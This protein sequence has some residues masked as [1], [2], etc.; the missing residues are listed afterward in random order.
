MSE[1]REATLV[2]LLRREV[3]LRKSEETQVAMQ[4]AEESVESE[5]MN[6][7]EDVQHRIIQEYR[8]ECDSSDAT[9]L[10]ITVHDLRQAALR[11]PEIAFWVKYN[12]ARRGD[13]KVGDVAP[14]VPLY[15]AVDGESTSLLAMP[16][17]GESS[18][19]KRMVVVAGSYS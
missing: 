18:A 9:L 1:S 5:W 3:E 7:V 19:A 6:V 8:Q 17:T 15:R 4:Q 16:L 14:D 11:H 10:S 12:R 2:Q 13:L